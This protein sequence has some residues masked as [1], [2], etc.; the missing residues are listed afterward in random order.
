M[1]LESRGCRRLVLVATL[2][3]N[4][5]IC[6]L[7]NYHFCYHSFA[8]VSLDSLFL[9]H[10]KGFWFASVKTQAAGYDPVSSVY[11]YISILV[12]FTTPAPIRET[13]RNPASATAHRGTLLVA[14]TI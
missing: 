11:N 2:V 10:R 9:S 14:L 1:A 13:C 12:I 5:Q 3:E 7:L 6:Y 8:L 4:F